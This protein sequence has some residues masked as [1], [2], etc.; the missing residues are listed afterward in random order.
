MIPAY[1]AETT[2]A[3]L[4]KEVVALGLPTIVVDDASVDRTAEIA[5][6]AGATVIRRQSNGGKG[7]ALRQGFREV[8]EKG[9][10]WCLTM[11]A[12]GQHLPAEIHRFLEAAL[13]DQADLIVGNR[14]GNPLGMPFKRRLTNRLMSWLLSRLAGRIIPDTQCGF[15]LVSRRVLE[16][17]P[18]TSERFEID[19]ELLV[20]AARSR[21]RI[22]SVPV[23]C[24]YRRE[25]SFVRPIKDTIRFFRFLACLRRDP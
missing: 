9:Y 14:M 3:P 23:S 24:V 20:K 11:D 22:L 5:R 15:R 12:D 17:V 16:K 13:R 21:F 6:L 19:S 4:V 25:S 10:R 7:T 8:L 1:Q 2:I 18:L